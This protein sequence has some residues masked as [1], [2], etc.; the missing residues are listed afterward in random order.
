MG[1]PWIG[2]A[3]L[4]PL[5][6]YLPRQIY[7]FGEIMQVD[8]SLLYVGHEASPLPNEKALFS[9]MAA[10]MARHRRIVIAVWLIA[11]VAAAPLAIVSALLVA[12]VS[13]W[14]LILTAFVGVNQWLY[15]VFGAC[16]ASLVLKRFGI[17]P[18]C[19]W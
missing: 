1:R 18:Q 10:F 5:G 7:E 6:V 16:P 4:I 13:P 8:E 2:V 9:R 14:F 3:I 19:G 11:T 17:A 15:V 12:I